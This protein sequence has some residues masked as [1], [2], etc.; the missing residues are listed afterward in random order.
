M[1]KP[2]RTD[3]GVEKRRPW[4]HMKSERLTSVSLSFSLSL[5]ISLS[6]VSL[7]RIQQT[8]HKLSFH[9]RLRQVRWPH[10]A[11]DIIF[12]FKP[13]WLATA[14]VW[15]KSLYNI[16]TDLSPILLWQTHHI[17]APTHTLLTKIS[18]SLSSDCSNCWAYLLLKSFLASCHCTSCHILCCTERLSQLRRSHISGISTSCASKLLQ[19]RYNHGELLSYM[20][21][22]CLFWWVA[23][24]GW[25]DSFLTGLKLIKM[26]LGYYVVINVYIKCWGVWCYVFR[27]NHFTLASVL[28][29]KC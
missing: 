12:D 13:Q 19:I 15:M 3:R 18:F 28:T 2:E 9:N 20:W 4:Q 27:C 10:T 14:E 8:T 1:K 29:Q 24:G 21:E 11:Q 17:T 26:I 7:T 22:T 16:K 25:R 6:V 23:S 5:S